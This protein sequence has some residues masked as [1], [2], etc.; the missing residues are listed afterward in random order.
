[1]DLEAGAHQTEKMTSLPGISPMSRNNPPRQNSMSNMF[2]PKQVNQAAKQVYLHNST[3]MYLQ[4][5]LHVYYLLY[6]SRVSH[7]IP[8]YPSILSIQHHVDLF[9]S[10][11]RPIHTWIW[12]VGQVTHGPKSVVRIAGSHSHSHS[13][14]LVHPPPNFHP[15]PP[16]I[17]YYD[18]DSIPLSL[19]CKFRV[20][21][22]LIE[23]PKPLF[24]SL[25]R[26]PSIGWLVEENKIWV[27]CSSGDR[28]RNKA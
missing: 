15:P 9:C 3:H 25:P 4:H 2:Q 23:Q 11:L 21:Y 17:M 18:D 14:F 1:M 26:I 12:Y 5:K 7:H 20:E 16:A 10:W 6:L 28:Y 24:L 19:F 8:S 22:V 27:C 13:P